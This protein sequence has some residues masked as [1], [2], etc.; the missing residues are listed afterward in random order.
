MVRV[1]HTSELDT[2]TL[3]SARALLDDVFAGELTDSDWEHSLGGMHAFIC[4]HGALIAHAA[5]VQRRLIYRDNALRCGYVE[6][7]AVRCLRR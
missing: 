3:A 1:A 6:A 7:L 4:H 2:A 5:V